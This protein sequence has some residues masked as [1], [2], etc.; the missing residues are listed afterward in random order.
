MPE[1]SPQYKRVLLKISGEFL[2]GDAAF[3]IQPDILHRL[4]EEI[5]QTLTAGAEVAL[6]VGGGNLFRGAELQTAGI[7]RVTGDQM[8]M[9]ATVMNALAL[10]DVFQHIGLDAQLMSAIE[11]PGVAER[12][13]RQRAIE[14]LDAARPVIFAAGTGNPLFTTDS[15]ACLRGIEIGADLVLKGTRVDGVYTGDPEQDA[16]AQFIP[17]LS[18]QQ[19]LSE[20]LQVMDLTAIC[21]C[22]AHS[23][24]IR[25]FNIGK[26]GALSDIMAGTPHGTLISDAV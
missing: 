14:H 17:R 18:Y 15:A 3:G 1:S 4:A 10:R 25:V 5:A 6:V 19:I 7:E 2:A 12:Y 23:M 24:P 8:G 26:A 22:L 11:M 21:L 20:Q 9:L 16:N 13:S